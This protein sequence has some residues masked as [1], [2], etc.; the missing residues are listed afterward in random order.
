M[1]NL[2]RSRFMVVSMRRGLSHLVIEVE[3]G[4]EL[5]DLNEL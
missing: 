2:S 4:S 5:I 1:A 3:V